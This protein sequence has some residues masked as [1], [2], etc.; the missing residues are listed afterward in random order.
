M[1]TSVICGFVPYI[2]F[3][4]QPIEDRIPRQRVITPSLNAST[5]KILILT[6]G[7]GKV[8]VVTLPY[9]S[10][11]VLWNRSLLGVE[12]RDIRVTGGVASLEWRASQRGNDKS[13]VVSH[14]PARRVLHSTTVFPI[15]P[16]TEASGTTVPRRVV[17]Q[18]GCCKDNETNTLRAVPQTVVRPLPFPSFIINLCWILNIL[19]LYIE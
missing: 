11:R 6:V 14:R 9:P 2:L 19:S 16:G 17:L 5:A 10:R 1:P 8:I 12:V 13:F 4:A 15:S 7:Q 3:A 18:A